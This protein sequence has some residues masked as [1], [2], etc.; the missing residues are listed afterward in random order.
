L[1]DVGSAMQLQTDGGR[2]TV[3]SDRTGMVKAARLLLSSVT[4]V[5]VLADRIVIKQI[6][7]SRNKVLVT[8]DK[9]EKVSTFQEFVQIF[10]QFGNEMVEFAHLTGDRQNG[11]TFHIQ[12]PP[13]TCLRHPD[14]E[15]A[16]IN[17]DA[18]FHR[19]RCALEQ[20]I[21]I[22]TE[23][24]SCGENKVL[25]TSIYNSIKDFKVE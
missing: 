3:F 23:A 21:E 6:I 18:V 7:R 1:T 16:R 9:L 22:V 15:S 8:L 13:Q 5:L 10:S 2:V 20:V 12:L 11:L 25:P 19:M 4:K 17:K 24:R 14:C